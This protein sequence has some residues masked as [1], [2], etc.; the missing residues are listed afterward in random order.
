L[1][2]L[3][4]RQPGERDLAALV[5]PLLGLEVSPAARRRPAPAWWRDQGRSGVG[6][7]GPYDV[8]T[9]LPLQARHAETG[10]PMVWIPAGR[11]TMG[12][13]AFPSEQPLHEV[14]VDGFYLG[15]SPVPVHTYAEYT[16]ATGAAAPPEWDS[17]LEAVERPVVFVDWD[18]AAAF[19]AWAGGRLPREAEWEWA[20][21]GDDGRF[22]PWGDALPHV[23]W[24]NL[25]QAGGH[26][27]RW[28]RYL[29]EVEARPSD[30]SP[31]S[32]RDLGGN[33]QDWCADWYQEGYGPEPVRRNPPGPAS[34]NLRVVRGGCWEGDDASPSALRATTRRAQR[35]VA[36]RGSCGFRL[37]VEVPGGDPA[38]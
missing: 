1:L 21:R 4:R 12:S 16:G 32:V 2:A 18:Q 8:R 9:G 20:A 38:P 36:R 5:L 27:E 3:W 22:F 37:L 7:D 14:L 13:L 34:G 35:P 28:D 10:L 6:P 23:S 11:F 24:V 29:E 26:P 33:V 19:C 31:F 15:R 17:Q 25:G 30:A